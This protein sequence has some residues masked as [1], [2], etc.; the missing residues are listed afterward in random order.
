[1]GFRPALGEYVLHVRPLFGRPYPEAMRSPD[2]FDV[3]LGDQD[4]I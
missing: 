3:H 2:T 1:M 4:F